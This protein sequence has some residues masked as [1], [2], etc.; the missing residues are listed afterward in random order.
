VVSEDRISDDGVRLVVE[1]TGSD[2]EQIIR[3]RSDLFSC[4]EK[5]PAESTQSI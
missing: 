4:Y 2:V 5:I 3:S 1:G